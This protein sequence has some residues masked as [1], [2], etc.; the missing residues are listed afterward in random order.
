MDRRNESDL[1]APRQALRLVL[2][3]L[4]DDVESTVEL[5]R[6]IEAPKRVRDVLVNLS[7][8]LI[9]GE[10]GDRGP[11]VLRRMIEEV[12]PIHPGWTIRQ[13]LMEDYYN[14]RTPGR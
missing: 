1:D 3:Q 9:D 14:N 11:E 4:E 8:Q 5:E 7:A 10:V 2:L 12:D 13:V 6:R